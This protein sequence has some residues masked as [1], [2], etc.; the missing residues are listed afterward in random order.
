[1]KREA[2]GWCVWVRFDR[3][4]GSGWSVYK[5]AATFQT[6]S[7]YWTAHKMAALGKGK[8]E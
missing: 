2:K 5:L 6:L 1:M 3:D 8:H 4:D 7:P